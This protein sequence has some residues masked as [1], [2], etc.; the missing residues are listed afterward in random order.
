MIKKF[1]VI[2]LFFSLIFLIGA[3]SSLVERYL[4][5]ANKSYAEKDYAKAFGY[6][7]YVCGQFASDQTPQNVEI[8]AELVYYDYLIYMRDTNDLSEFNALKAKLS[9]FPDITSDRISRLVRTLNQMETQASSW[10]T[11]TTTVLDLQEI[12]RAH[13]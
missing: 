6:I 8:L 5:A 11:T 2:L 12:G 10:N 1:A 13:V 9:E 3:Q 4:D 7:N